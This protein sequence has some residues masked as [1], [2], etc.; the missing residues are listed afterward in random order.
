MVQPFF[1]TLFG[2][3][4][5][6]PTYGSFYHFRSVLSRLA[7]AVTGLSSGNSAFM[8]SP[9]VGVSFGIS[10]VI[11]MAFFLLGITIRP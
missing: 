7:L 2:F 9:L 6:F 4:C 1:L 8:T 3:S 5:V 11:F 10:I